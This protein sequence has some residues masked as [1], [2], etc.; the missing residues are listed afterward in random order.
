MLSS[1]RTNYF[2]SSPYLLR[3][4]KPL[5]MALSSPSGG[6]KTTIKNR[7]FKAYQNFYYS[8]SSTTRSKRAYEVDGVDYH[9]V[10]EKT[11]LEQKSQGGFL[12]DVYVK[13]VYYGTRKE[14][15][16]SYQ[17]GQDILFDVDRQGV[18]VLKKI[19]PQLTSIFIIPPSMA[20]L[21]K[22]LRQRNTETE[23]SLKKRLDRAQQ[24][25]ND[26]YHYDYIFINDKIERVFK[27]ISKVIYVEKC[28]TQYREVIRDE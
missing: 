26:W 3:H 23:E 7:I 17:V 15:L 28:K 24:E 10:D 1:Q 21:E 5:C 16:E 20:I 8:V 6:G 18:E 25:M 14:C 13:G 11:F 2:S 9:F 22:R 4:K 19:F 12:E 27:D